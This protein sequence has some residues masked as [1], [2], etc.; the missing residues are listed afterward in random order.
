MKILDIQVL[1]GPNFWTIH[2]KV[3]V[4]KLDIGKYEELPSD[5][6]DGFYF[7]LQQL[8]PGLYEHE[9]S[10][11]RPGGFLERVKSGTW[12]GH[13]VEHIA[14]ELQNIAGMKCNFGKTRGTGQKGIY[15]IVIS[16]EVEKAAI[17][18]I[19]AAVTIAD[20]LS[21]GVLYN[22]EKDIDHLCRIALEEKPGPSTTAIINAAVA[23]GIPYITDNG[24]LV[25]FGYGRAQKRID[26]TITDNTS[27]IAVD[28][29]SD[30]NRTKALLKSSSVPVPDGDF[31]YDKLDLIRV[32]TEV[33]YPLVIKPYNRS[34]GKGVTM[35]IQTYEEAVAGFEK[36]KA[37]SEG[38]LVEKF[39]EGNDY[40]L[41]VINNMLIAA[42]QRTP[43]M[44]IG[45]DESTIRELI[46]LTNKHPTR[47]IDHENILT[48]I[49]IDKTT[50]ETL[51]SQHVSLDTVPQKGRKIYLKQTAN[52]SMG[53]TSEDVT[54]FLHPEII[55]LAERVAQIVGLDICGIDI[56]AEDISKPVSAGKVVV[57]E[58]NAAPGFRMHTHPYK[59]KP[60]PAGE[61]VINMLFPGTTDGRIPLVA[62]TG[63]NGKT[64][65]AR[66]IAHIAKT[67]G[68]RTGYTTT[69]GIYIN[70]IRIEE[71]D[72]TGYYSGQK[73]LRDKTVDFAVLECARGGMLRNGLAF[74]QCD[75]GIVTN[76]ADDHLG[77]NGIN[78]LEEMAE[79]KSIVPESVKR[80]GLAILNEND[81]HSY[82]MKYK[83]K[84]AI[85][86]FSV[87]SKS[88][89]INEHCSKG[90]I[91]AIYK[92][93]EILLI[94]G[95]RLIMK[96]TVKNIPI[97]FGGKAQF[98]IE[99][100]LAAILASYFSNF[101]V[102]HIADALYS[103]HPT[104]ENIPGRM[105]LIHFK[106]FSFLLDYAHNL[107]GIKAI[108]PF[109]RQTNALSKIGIIT[110]PGD[111]RDIDIINMGKACGE[112]FDK[113]II[114][115]DEDT[116]G[117]KAME[118]IDLIH[119]GIKI[120][121]SKN[122]SVEIIM[123][124][125][126]A[127]RYALMNATT[128]SLIVLLSENIQNSYKI[129]TE[130]KQR[131]ENLIHED[132]SKQ[133]SDYILKVGKNNLF[134]YTRKKVNILRG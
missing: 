23:R 107:H 62:V 61:A 125:A 42:A 94:N 69:D 51:D 37:L 3:I 45:N 46:E 50:E 15:N 4:V 59:G 117:R 12:I 88:K 79:V 76:V 75:V 106:N 113:I 80:D 10:E 18:A 24:K 16:F 124:E 27:C 17:Y 55:L 116:R 92:D 13:I 26:A 120:S 49:R 83:L 129:L 28:L 73:I 34:Q 74:D 14:L 84:C 108:E 103:F 90:G 112:I 65:T 127:V 114:R 134:E 39:V 96:E 35:K 11:G 48:K 60:R 19:N 115:T 81:D 40:R 82:D 44:V 41:L 67:A 121:K 20:A 85:A 104:Y 86:L 21:N 68:Y 95:N 47:G 7:R 6:I 64:T 72:C 102:K 99:N 122:N 22:I 9:C 98:M 56:I 77:L 36:A 58:V 133:E 128:R 118:I 89:R 130:F 66:L 105:N 100:V 87:N 2:H 123:N 57:I 131:E 1:R 93:G 109:I 31:I 78:T 54:D 30:K 8:L 33:G 52:L 71:G 5:R 70:G 111:R 126:E 63:T 101:N 53:G 25:Q 29:A 132:H 97:T 32:I 91:A 110:A 119:S 43:A 38:V